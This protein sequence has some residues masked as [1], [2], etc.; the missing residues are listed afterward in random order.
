MIDIKD[1]VDC[2]G[3]NACGDI[4]PKEAIS[5]NV[6][7]EGFEYPIVDKTL[8]IECGLCEKV[9]PI[10]NI[11]KLK[12][13]DYV[14]P[15]CYAAIH[16]N[17]EIRFDSTSGGIFSALAE[18]MYKKGGYVG[19]AIWTQDW[20]VKEFISNN[21]ND[22][23]LLR[24]SK[25][26]QSLSEGFYKEV[27]VLLLRGESVLV[28]G[29]PCQM[30]ALRSFLNYKNY[31][32]LIIVDFIC[33]GV[34][35]PKVWRSYLNYKEKEYG[36]KVIYIK[37]KNKEMGWRQLTTKLVF[38]NKKVLYDTKETSIFTR[39]YIGTHAYC[40][41]SCY[42]CKFKGF[43]RISDISIADYWGGEKQIGADLDND[44]G[45]SLVMI[46]SIKGEN[47]YELIKN[48]VKGEGVPFQSILLGNKAL[49]ESLS[50]P[51]IDREKFYEDLDKFSFD[52]MSHKY[53]FDLKKSLSI[54]DRLKNIYLFVSGVINVSRCN[55]FTIWKNIRYNL[56]DHRF[57]TNII[58]GDFIL[59]NR[60]VLLDL[61][62]SA[63]ITIHGTFNL[64]CRTRFPNSNLETR[65]LMEENSQIILD[66]YFTIGYGSDI[67]IFHDAVLHCHGSGGSNIGLTI[68][69]GEKIEIGKGVMIG[70]NV[71]IRD[72][73]GNHYIARRGYKNSHPVK[74]G[75]HSWLCEGCA[76]IGG[77][78]IG[79]C[80]IVGAKAM[81]ACHCPSFTMVVGNPA[82]VV[83]TDIY[84]KF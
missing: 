46:N 83:D 66:D 78:S 24:S 76:I 82:E 23:P 39:G 84:W 27:K 77:A 47:Y 21:I 42:E 6:D 64:G 80:V 2:C 61:A 26:L 22:L 40:R 25:Y 4:C 74:I 12:K 11:N 70:R 58:K 9:C 16:K 54:R 33:L 35:S 13:N 18:T 3:C 17:I 56:F 41:P 28:C 32:N 57:K 10:I 1:K 45:T 36:G 20:H 14:E 81:V 30:A 63:K 43:P 50:K 44:M 55:I 15:K 19:G 72:N 29:T 52:E 62:K 5:Y 51:N 34:N 53:G 75:Q 71:M 67:E 59:I 60:R 69:C 38:D 79:D 48:K 65:L 73:N 31:E 68:I 7:K 49:E 8:C 37:P